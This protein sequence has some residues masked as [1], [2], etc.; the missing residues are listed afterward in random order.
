MNRTVQPVLPDI[1]PAK[2]ATPSRVLSKGAAA[3]SRKAAREMPSLADTGAAGKV[4]PDGIAHALQERIKE[5]NCLYGIARLADTFADSIENFLRGVVTLLPPAWQ[6]PE[7]TLARIVYRGRSYETDGFSL[8]PWSQSAAITVGSERIGDVTVCY[9]EKRPPSFEG[10]FLKEERSLIDG[11]AE[12]LSTITRRIEAEQ[13]LVEMNRLLEVER[14][15]LREMN[16]ALKM[17]LSKIDEE[18]KDLGER[19][20]ANVERVVLPILDALA[21]ELPAA[22]STYVTLLRGSLL[23]I[24][25]PYAKRLASNTAPLTPTEIA[26]CQMIRN[27]MRTKDI[28]ALRGISVSTVNRHRE[29][30]R[31][32]LGLTRTAANLA[33]SLQSNG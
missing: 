9:R 24:A 23:D 31:R 11:I 12:Y 3:R 18:K 14:Q 1:A 5:L 8:S 29:H 19:I 28:A 16:S 33:A 32:K 20:T 30:I 26:I 17:V 6:Y 27:G 2:G 25:S 7:T 22:K 10:P 4:D 13:K 15:S 21:L